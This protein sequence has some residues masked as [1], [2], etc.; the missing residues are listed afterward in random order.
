MIQT[1]QLYSSDS[2]LIIVKQTAQQKIEHLVNQK[3][4]V[5]LYLQ[6]FSLL[7]KGRMGKLLL[8]SETLILFVEI[9]LLFVCV[10]A[11]SRCS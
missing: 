11:P 3:Q 8:L 2:D 4:R 7:P 6:I 1:E 9:L 5:W 10:C